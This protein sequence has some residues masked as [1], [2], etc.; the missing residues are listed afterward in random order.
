MVAIRRSIIPTTNRNYPGTKINPTGG[1]WV[2]VHETGSTRA[3]ANARSEEN[4][5]WGGGG[6]SSVAYHFAVDHNEAIQLLP[7]DI[8]GWHAGDGCDSR[9]QDVGCFASVAIET[10]V[11]DNNK[12]KDATRKN[13]LEL[14]QAIITGD[15]RLHY[16]TTDSDRFSST[17][18]APHK[19]WSSYSKNCPYF[20]LADG[21]FWTIESKVTAAL[22]SSKPTPI[23]APPLPIA[24]LQPYKSG[25]R[26]TV[27][28]VVKLADGNH[29]FFVA[30]T[31]ETIRETPRLQSFAADSPEIGPII[32][33]GESF[34]VDWIVSVGDK[35]FYVSPWNTVVRVEDTKR[36]RDGQAA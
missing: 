31:V 22:A 25:D 20:M 32:K 27:P 7:L 19:R 3:G 30:D 15:S 28:S 1:L 33:L 10:C 12:Y 9:T 29:A 8:I 26:N 24:E 21:Y 6:S 16:G 2:T 35:N 4:F 13:L 23:Y 11:G 14:I 18:I 34:K 17:R 5:M 36:V